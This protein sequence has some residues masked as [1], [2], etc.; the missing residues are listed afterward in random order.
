M[1]LRHWRLTRLG[2]DRNKQKSLAAEAA[3][4]AEVKIQQAASF[5]SSA[6]DHLGMFAE[7]A[8]RKT[9]LVLA[10]VSIVV[11]VWVPDPNPNRE[12]LFD[13]KNYHTLRRTGCQ[14]A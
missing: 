10:S 13:D 2:H 9:S 7:D 11:T 14:D 1:R 8:M 12:S 6:E 4:V 3:P 5:A